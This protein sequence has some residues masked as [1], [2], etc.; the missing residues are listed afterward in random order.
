MAIA[1]LVVWGWIVS[2]AIARAGWR[3]ES[4]SHLREIG[5]EPPGWWQ[6]DLLKTVML[7]DENRDRLASGE[8]LYRVGIILAVLQVAGF[9]ALLGVAIVAAAT[10][11]V[12]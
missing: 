4:R 10:G 7:V 5:V 12:G 1:F 8:T 6:K 11:R 9:V 3:M 2:V